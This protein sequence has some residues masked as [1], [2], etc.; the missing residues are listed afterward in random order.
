MITVRHRKGRP[1]ITVCWYYRPEQVRI[2]AD[3]YWLVPDDLY[4]T[5]H[6]PNRQFWE[7]EV[8]K[9][10]ESPIILKSFFMLTS[11]QVTLPTTRLKTSS[12]RLRV[13]SQPATSADVPVLLSGTQAGHYMCATP[14]ITTEIASLS[15]SRT[16]IPVFLK[17]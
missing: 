6:P 12:K 11:L 5:F 2:P 17:K 16:G 10:S 14:D 1:G 9:T 7:G 13:N 3:Q 15:E 8:F 4:Q